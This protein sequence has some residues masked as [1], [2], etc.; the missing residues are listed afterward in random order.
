MVEHIHKTGVSADEKRA[1]MDLADVRAGFDAGDLVVWIP[2]KRMV[3][4]CLT[5]H[6]TLDEEVESIKSLLRDGRLHLRFTDGSEERH[7][8]A[9]QRRAKGAHLSQRES[10]A[11]PVPAEF[12]SEDEAFSNLQP[13]LEKS[14]GV[15]AL[16]KHTGV[17]LWTGKAQRTADATTRVS[18]VAIS[19]QA[20]G[21]MRF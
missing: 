9:E 18:S 1:A 16:S 8:S 13:R 11:R 6:L 3:A 19:L 10:A 5:K 15:V 20:R 2:T 17:G 4:D 14:P 21:Q 7:L 12:D